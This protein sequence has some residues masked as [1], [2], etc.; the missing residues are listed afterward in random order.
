M[1]SQTLSYEEADAVVKEIT[2]PG[3]DY[4][5]HLLLQFF[6]KLTRQEADDV[7][8]HIGRYIEKVGTRPES[9]WSA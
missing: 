7:L 9:P 5:G 6:V 1:P 8:Y 3:Y 4:A 2:A